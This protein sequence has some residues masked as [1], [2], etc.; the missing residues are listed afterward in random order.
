MIAELGLAL[1]GLCMTVAA[2]YVARKLGYHAGY[3]VGWDVGCDAAWDSG[4]SRAVVDGKTAGQVPARGPEETET[5]EVQAMAETLLYEYETDPTC[6]KCEGSDV[7]VE[8]CQ[9]EPDAEDSPDYLTCSCRRCEFIWEMACADACDEDAE[10]EAAGDLGCIV[11]QPEFDGYED[12]DRPTFLSRVTKLVRRLVAEL[13]QARKDAD[14][15]S[16]EAA[17][18]RSGW[19]S[20]CDAADAV[21]PAIQ[22]EPEGTVN[23]RP[24]WA[25][26]ADCVQRL[27]KERDEWRRLFCDSGAC[28]YQLFGFQR[29]E[30][31]GPALARFNWNTIAGRLDRT[32]GRL[33]KLEDLLVEVQ[34]LHASLKR[35]GRGDPI[36]T[37]ALWRAMD[38]AKPDPVPL[39]LAHM[40]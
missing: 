4:Y 40:G 25:R 35:S 13:D 33:K 14:Q 19:Q 1:I 10:I 27:R 30:A 22:W 32:F 21:T 11:D 23:G 3:E 18:H 15:T 12:D 38:A 34:K 37:K 2:W 16:R 6:P 5:E 31:T 28:V 39:D 36:E 8:Y 26:A 7:A 29:E 17:L 9:D 20:L 24:W